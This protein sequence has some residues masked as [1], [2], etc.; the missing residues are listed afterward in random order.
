MLTALERVQQGFT[1]LD[2]NAYLK[3]FLPRDALSQWSRNKPTWDGAV[4]AWVREIVVP[5]L[6]LESP[7]PSAYLIGMGFHK[8]K[9]AT[10]EEL[11]GGFVTVGDDGQPLQNLR[12]PWQRIRDTWKKRFE[13]FHKIEFEAA[14][15]KDPL[16]ILGPQARDEDLPVIRESLDCFASLRPCPGLCRVNH[17]KCRGSLR[18]NLFNPAKRGGVCD[19]L[20]YRLDPSAVAE[21]RKHVLICSTC[22]G[23][24]ALCE[25]VDRESCIEYFLPAFIYQY[26]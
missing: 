4:K 5:V 6:Q 20:S 25:D 24:A 22:G 16:F 21:H 17:D 7:T 19:R 23:F 9:A 8:L 12:E 14:S 11:T 3:D 26:S 18:D 2:H 10:L 15:P 13:H 1:S